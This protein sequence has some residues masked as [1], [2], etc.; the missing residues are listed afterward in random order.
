MRVSTGGQDETVPE[1]GEGRRKSIS[2]ETEALLRAFIDRRHDEGKQ[3]WRRTVGDD[4]VRMEAKEMQ[5]RIEREG[6]ATPAQPWST[7]VSTRAVGGF[8]HRLQY[9]RRRGRIKIPPFTEEGKPLMRQFISK[10]NREVMLE[11]A[12]THFRCSWM[13]IF[14]IKHMDQLTRIF[15]V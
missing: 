9:K 6:E 1:G 3:V 7:R 15:L 12:G 5:E 11:E 14:S 8:L 13:N 10:Y 4:I 2:Q